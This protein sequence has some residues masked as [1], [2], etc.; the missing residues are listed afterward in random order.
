MYN[1]KVK[2]GSIGRRETKID[3]HH[4][5]II[6]SIIIKKTKKKRN[7]SI[8]MIKATNIDKMGVTKNTAAKDKQKNE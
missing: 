3:S 7:K 8:L 1:R 4:I 6:S 5:Q 2:K